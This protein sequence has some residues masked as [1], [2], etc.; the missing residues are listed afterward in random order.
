MKQKR[1]PK[2]SDCKKS[3]VDKREVRTSLKSLYSAH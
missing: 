2:V 1:E 3:H